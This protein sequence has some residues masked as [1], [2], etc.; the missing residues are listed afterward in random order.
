MYCWSSPFG[1]SEKFRVSFRFRPFNLLTS[2]TAR[3]QRLARPSRP[4]GGAASSRWWPSLFLA[5][6]VT[7]GVF[8]LGGIV[9]SSVCS[10][11][12]FT[13]IHSRFCHSVGATANMTFFLL[14]FHTLLSSCSFQF[15]AILLLCT[16]S[17]L[18]C[19]HILYS[20]SLLVGNTLYSLV[21]HI[22]LW[23]HRTLFA[24]FRWLPPLDLP[25]VQ[26]ILQSQ[27]VLLHRTI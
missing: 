3:P 19:T 8:F 9:R 13:V 4:L 14:L 22:L 1:S 25:T 27:F 6:W 12:S 15:F 2:C 21:P 10:V 20:Q 16:S 18:I 24:S 26:S 17:T 7:H 23:A 11:L 5:T